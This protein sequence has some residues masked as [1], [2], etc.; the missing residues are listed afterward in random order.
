MGEV[1]G[2]GMELVR[3][4]SGKEGFLALTGWLEMMEPK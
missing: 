3:V 1:G 4:G 2:G